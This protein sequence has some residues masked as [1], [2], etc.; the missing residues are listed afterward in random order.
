MVVQLEP[1]TCID[2]YPQDPSC[3]LGDLF[4]TV[5]LGHIFADGKQFPDMEPLVAPAEILA[6]WRARKPQGEAAIL[7]FVRAYFKASPEADVTPAPT[8]DLADHLSAMWDRLTRPATPQIPYSSAISLPNAYVVPGGRFRECYYW[9][10]YFAM[11]GLRLD[12]RTELIEGMIDNFVSLIERFGHVPNGNRSYFLSRSQPPFLAGML[13]LSPV[14]DKDVRWRRLQ[15]LRSEHAYWMR[16]ADWLGEQAACEHVVAMPDGTLLNRFWDANDTPRPES[17]AEDVATARRSGR[18]PSEVYRDLRAGA[19]SGWDFSSRWLADGHTLESI[20]TTAIVPCDLNSLMF[21]SEQKI[22]QELRSFDC[23]RDA[24]RYDLAAKHR[25]DAMH[26]Y[27][28]SDEEGRFGDWHMARATLCRGATAATLYPLY[29]G[30]A[31]AGQAA[32]VGA[33][34]TNLLLAPGGLR[35][36]VTTTGQQWDAPNGWAPLQWIAAE[37]LR[38]YGQDAL[39]ETISGRW[40]ATVAHRFAETGMIF[41]KYDVED[42]RP[43]GGG[44]YPNQIGFGWTNGVVQGFLARRSL[45]ISHK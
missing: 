1:A 40:I 24:E 12:G 32:R 41:E 35:T 31:S 27:L 23:A 9:D 33:T 19:E 14:G 43:A 18:V 13:D 21:A 45:R 37:G 44:E 17:Y 25:A 8:R 5:Q 20:E 42:D 3:A 39:A 38:R 34:V 15:A 7:E 36:T 6:A 28:W 22:A 16:G 2:A 10:S 11:I 4:S 29:V 26:R 30:L